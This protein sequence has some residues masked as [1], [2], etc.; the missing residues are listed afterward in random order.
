MKTKVL[1]I[2]PSMEI[3]GIETSL[4]GLLD[5]IDY[6]KY[7]VDLFLMSHTGDLMPSINRNVNLLPE[8]KLFSLIEWSTKKLLL[9]GHWY[10]CAIKLFSKLYGKIRS[11]FTHKSSVYMSFC[12]RLITKRIKPLSQKYDV[13]LGFIGQFYFVEGIIDAKVKVDWAHTDFTASHENYDFEYYRSMWGKLD[14]IACV[15]ESVRQSFISIYPDFSDKTVVVENV[16]SK[17][18][19]QSRS[20]SFDVE[21]EMPNDGV[22]N[23]LT[24]GRFSPAKNF[25]GAI[26][27]C[28]KLVDKGLNIRWY[29][30]GYGL[31]EENLRKKINQLNLKE[32]VIILGKKDN[33]YP[34]IKA[35]DLYVQ[36]SK[37]EGKSV[38]VIEAQILG[39]PVLITRYK[40]SSS[41][42]EEGVDGHICELSLD[43]IV[44]GV[45]YMIQHPEYANV[46]SQNCKNRD[47]SNSES[48]DIETLFLSNKRLHI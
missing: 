38:T 39:K 1:V 3:G 47:Y 21:N 4:I 23:I 12:K 16:L 33:P 45:E 31:G 43:G 11:L 34:Y 26:D 5:S 15:S 17:E 42:L 22:Y 7:D 8:E 25:E 28:K 44:D 37:Y 48:M 18:H 40:T 24:I 27:A 10:V 9:A 14:Y 2:G 20:E 32:R 13:A 29:F 30:I 41:Q 19:I 36:P 6:S 46:L 35:C